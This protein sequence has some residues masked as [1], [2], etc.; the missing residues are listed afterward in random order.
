LA[1]GQLLDEG[2]VEAPWGAVIDVLDRGIG[3]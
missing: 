3:S 1:P 2:F